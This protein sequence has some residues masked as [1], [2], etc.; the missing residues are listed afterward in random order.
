MWAGSWPQRRSAVSCKGRGGSLQR[1]SAASCRGEGATCRLLMLIFAQGPRGVRARQDGCPAAV[2][3]VAYLPALW[4]QWRAYP[5]WLKWRAC[6]RFG[7]QAQRMCAGLPCSSFPASACLCSPRLC[8]HSCHKDVTAIHR[9]STPV[10][11]A[12]LFRSH[13]C[14]D[15]TPAL[16]SLPRAQRC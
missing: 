12:L 4:L 2:A 8:K 14:M 10:W 5:L 13:P 16:P 3:A 1:Q 7:V 11:T 6:L 15:G 9:D